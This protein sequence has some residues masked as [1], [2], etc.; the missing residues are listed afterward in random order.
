MA[1]V[2]WAKAVACQLIV[3]HHL[4]LYGSRSGGLDT[5]APNFV[6]WA[7]SQA[8]MAVQIFLVVGG[9]LAS[10]SLWPEPAQP[11]ASVTQWPQLLWR[12]V[13]RLGPPYWVALGV[14]IVAA[15]LARLWLD[16]PDTPAAPD[17][18]QVLSHVAFAQGLLDQP[19][20]ST[21]L[22]YVAIDLQLFMLLALLAGVAQRLGPGSRRTGLLILIG[23]CAASLLVFNLNSDLDMW[24]LYFFGAY[25]LGVLAQWG[26]QT[27]RRHHAALWV[28]AL[29]GAALVLV[30]RDR[31]ALAGLTS[32]AL[33]LA[34][35]TLPRPRWVAWLARISYGVFLLHYPVSLAVA[36]MLE[37]VAPEAVT[38]G[39]GLILIWLCSLAAGWALTV[40]LE[41][42]SKQS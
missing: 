19:A 1:A 22:W 41:P 42:R 24:G 14:A 11:Q 7:A 29:V 26:R 33:L 5:L 2:D 38:D 3:W 30:W 4:V 10:R 35:D 27:G 32:L 20:L 15:A 6:H 36:A 39:V 8:L 25:G 34:P 28:L 40:A 23:A 21:G 13:R 16:D 12:R 17:L 31:I 37:A 9:F 18:W